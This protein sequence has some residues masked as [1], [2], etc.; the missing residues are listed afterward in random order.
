MKDQEDL[1]D[2]NR[3][4]NRG[5]SSDGGVCVS[6]FPGMGVF[7]DVRKALYFYWNGLHRR[8][9]KTIDCRFKLGAL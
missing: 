2:G 9:W 7:S 8:V 1:I 5:H 4:Q 3:S 6:V